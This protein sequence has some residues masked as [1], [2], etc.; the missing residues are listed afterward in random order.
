MSMSIDPHLMDGRTYKP[1]VLKLKQNKRP[2]Q[3]S[4]KK[5]KGQKT[6]CSKKLISFSK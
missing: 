5:I 6:D 2:P 3:Q 4:S 1:E